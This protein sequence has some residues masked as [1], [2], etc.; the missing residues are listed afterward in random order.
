M[1]PEQQAVQE[2]TDRF[3]ILAMKR[4][5]GSFAKHLAEAALYADDANLRLIKQTWP[6]YW[7]WYTRLAKQDLIADAA[8]K[9][10]AANFSEPEGG[11]DVNGCDV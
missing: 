8:A 3:V 10:H 1:T 2:L 6:V 11:K 4:L 9:L 7:E 5:G